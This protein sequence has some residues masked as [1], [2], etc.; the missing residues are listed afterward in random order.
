MAP[1]LFPFVSTLWLAKAKLQCGVM[2]VKSGTP[3]LESSSESSTA[4]DSFDVLTPFVAPIGDYWYLYYAGGPRSGVN[5]SCDPYGYCWD[6]IGVAMSASPAGPW[7]RYGPPLMPLGTE[8]NF[9]CCP[10]LL[11]GENNVILWED[12][13]LHLIFNGNRKDDIYLATSR[14]GVDWEKEL[15]PIH[16]GYSPDILRVNGLLWL[17]SISKERTPWFVTLAVGPTWRTLRDQGPVLEA[18]TQPWE[19]GSLFYPFVMRGD[20]WTL[21]YSSYGHREVLGMPPGNVTVTAIGMAYSDDGRRWQ[22]CEVAWR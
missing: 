19:A 1:A 18:Q 17:F 16:R 5:A 14:N 9:H 13:K 15:E 11:R 6:Q 21:T 20:Q 12:G 4:F 10:S 8:D 22:K 3:D 2:L 7:I